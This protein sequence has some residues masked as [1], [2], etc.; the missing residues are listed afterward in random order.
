M[1][2]ASSASSSSLGP[3]RRRRLR[4][5]RATAP[6]RQVGPPHPV[7]VGLHLVVRPAAEHRPRMILSVPAGTASSS[8]LCRSSHCFRLAA[9]AYQDQPAAQLVPVTSTCSS[10]AA[11]AARRVIGLVRLPGA[12]VP[13]DHVARRRTRPWGS[14]PRTPGTRSG[15]PRRARRA[16]APWGPA[17]ARSGQPS[18]PA[19]RLSRTAGRSAAAGP[20]DAGRQTASGREQV[21]PS[22]W[23]GP[24]DGSGVR[25]KSRIDWYRASRAAGL[26]GSPVAGLAARARRLGILRCCHGQPTTAASAGTGPT[27]LNSQCG[28]QAGRGRAAI[29]RPRADRTGMGGNTTPAGPA[30]SAHHHEERARSEQRAGDGLHLLRRPVPARYPLA[31]GALPGRRTA[32]RAPGRA[33]A[34]VGFARPGA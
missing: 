21:S 30:G 16:A 6:A 7:R 4:L 8:S 10:P 19:P 34:A 25:S 27:H 26:A 20:G 9:A 1:P 12:D 23:R 18:S 13:D 3:V 15:D 33:P 22:R 24:P 28:L 2:S 29:P 14:R 32:P 31:R 11:T 5:G 17:S